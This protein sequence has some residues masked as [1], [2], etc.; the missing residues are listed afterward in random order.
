MVIKNSRQIGFKGPIFQ[1]HGFGNIKYVEAA[2]EAAEGMLFPA[3]RLLVAGVVP[4]SNRQ[5]AALGQHKRD[6]TQCVCAERTEKTEERFHPPKK[7]KPETPDFR[8]G[9]PRHKRGL[10]TA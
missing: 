1:S 6:R 3:G 9:S 4:K 5:K 10:P 7:K 8:V 2:G